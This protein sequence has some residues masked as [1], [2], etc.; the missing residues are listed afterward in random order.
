MTL[1]LTKAS[2]RRVGGEPPA[3]RRRSQDER[4]RP[5]WRDVKPAGGGI[6]FLEGPPLSFRAPDGS[7]AGANGFG[8]AGEL[9][10][11]RP[12]GDDG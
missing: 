11:A 10:V 9:L 2:G 6:L 8:D 4:R 7:R 1:A 5:T 12:A 3:R